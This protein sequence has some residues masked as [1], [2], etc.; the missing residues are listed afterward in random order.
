LSNINQSIQQLTTETKRIALNETTQK[1]SSCPPKQSEP[2]DEAKHNSYDLFK[3]AA[4][5]VG[6]SEDDDEE[7]DFEVLQSD[8]SNK[9]H[10]AVDQ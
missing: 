4:F 8:P 3:S 1:T 5:Q 10:R 2:V 7:D 9:H 6:E